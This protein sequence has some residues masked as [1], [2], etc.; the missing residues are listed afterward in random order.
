MLRR[1]AQLGGARTESVR[2]AT[3]ASATNH[4]VRRDQ[5]LVSQFA[6]NVRKARE[7]RGLSQDQLGKA[8]GLSI[9]EISRIER[10]GRDVRLTT[11]A[12]PLGA[13][14]AA[15]DELFRGLTLPTD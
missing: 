7:E 10:G 9:S 15:P 13:L 5:D 4:D 12:R 14:G 6:R 1:V 3:A 2:G 11:V 8:A